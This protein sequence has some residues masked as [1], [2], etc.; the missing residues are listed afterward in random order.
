M[1]R[2][3]RRQLEA[4]LPDA[5]DAVGD[6]QDA[7]RRAG[8]Q[9]HEHWQTRSSS[10]ER[11]GPLLL[12]VAE[13]VEGLEIALMR[14]LPGRLV[15]RAEP[16]VVVGRAG[17]GEQ[18]HGIVGPDTLAAQAIAPVVEQ[19]LI[20]VRDLEQVGLDERHVAFGEDQ[21]IGQ[22]LGAQ[23]T[24]LIER[25]AALLGDALDARFDRDAACRAE[26]LEQ[27]RLPEIDPGLDA[28]RDR[29]VD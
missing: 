6:Q 19:V 4:V 13:R 26:Q 10:R 20:V 1:R 24:A 8:W 29:A 17:I 7:P 21:A 9:G 16:R 22:L 2:K 27:L 18:R 23:A 11:Q 12:D 5:A 25:C 15:G 3:A 28:E 14:P